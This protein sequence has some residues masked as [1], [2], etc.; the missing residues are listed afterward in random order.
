MLTRVV[1]KQ[2]K[3]TKVKNK[4]VNGKKMFK[5]ILSCLFGGRGKFQFRGKD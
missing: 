4:F 3:T 2:A 5:R 1:A